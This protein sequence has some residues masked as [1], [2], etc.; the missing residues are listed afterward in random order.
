M[1]VASPFRIWLKRRAVL[2]M[3]RIPDGGLATVV[4]DPDRC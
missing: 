2:T 3:R 1:P 4:G